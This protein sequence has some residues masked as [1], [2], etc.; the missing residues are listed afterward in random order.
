[1]GTLGEDRQLNRCTVLCVWSS[2]VCGCC[3]NDVVMVC[4]CCTV[5]VL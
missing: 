2:C 3:T 4:R 5:G 1:M